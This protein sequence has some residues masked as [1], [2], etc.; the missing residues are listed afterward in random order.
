MG[1]P[2]H[3]VISCTS[4]PPRRPPLKGFLLQAVMA[5]LVFPAH[6]LKQHQLTTIATASENSASIRSAT[7]RPAP[8]SPSLIRSLHW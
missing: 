7:R 3:S 4:P 1:L 6:G 8:S 2:C 5:I